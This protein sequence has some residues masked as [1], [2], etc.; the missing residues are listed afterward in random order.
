MDKYKYILSSSLKGEL[1][2]DHLPVGHETSE[3]ILEKSDEFD[4]VFYHYSQGS[5]EFYG[6]A[7]PYL[8]DLIKQQGI[9]LE[10]TIKILRKKRLSSEYEEVYTG[11]LN[12]KDYEETDNN[13]GSI[14]LSIGESDTTES[15]LS[16]TDTVIG[17]DSDKGI[18]DNDLTI[19]VDKYVELYMT[20]MEIIT[21]S[22]GEF[23]K[24]NFGY[25]ISCDNNLLM[26]MVN[27]SANENVLSPAYIKVENLL[28][29]SNGGFTYFT[30]SRTSKVKIDLS[31]VIYPSVFSDNGIM[32]NIAT[33]DIIQYKL[34]S[35]GDAVDES[36]NIIADPD[37][38]ENI[39]IRKNYEIPLVVHNFGDTFWTESTQIIDTVEINMES[40]QCLII[41]ANSITGAGNFII[42]VPHGYAQSINI[43]ISEL[44]VT[45]NIKAIKPYNL[46]R[47]LVESMTG[48]T[49]NF[50]APIFE[51]GGEYEN[52][53]STNGLMLRGFTAAVANYATSFSDYFQSW[54]I[55]GNLGLGID[56][57]IVSIEPVDNFYESEVVLVIDDITQLTWSR[58]IDES[59]FY[60][61]VKSGCDKTAYDAE[62]GLKEFNNINE[63]ATPIKR[64]NNKFEAIPAHRIDG[65]GMTLLLDDRAEDSETTD[66]ESD[67]ENFIIDTKK[68]NSNYLQKGR[69]DFDYVTGI[70]GISTPINLNFTPARL[71]YRNSDRFTTGCQ[72]TGTKI[73]LTK[74]T[75]SNSLVTK[76]TGEYIEISEN[77]D[78]VIANLKNPRFSGFVLEFGKPVSFESFQFFKDNKRKRFAV[79][80][81]IT[82]EYH[83]GWIK[84]IKRTTET[85]LANFTLIEQK[86]GQ[87]TNTV[88][89]MID[90]LGNIVVNDNNEKITVNG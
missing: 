63:Y 39:A 11:I 45:R 61:S 74:Q 13:R 15:I 52:C 64:T 24:N 76:K 37:W 71:A 73:K 31:L 27:T 29:V 4:G 83:Y 90:N 62:G 59:L 17:Y 50:S 9:N 85:N 65:Y 23:Q 81:P 72:L 32:L 47:R 48:K 10:C 53:L 42:S 26:S 78:L 5:I 8:S 86:D 36:G 46:F 41:Y 18:D 44:P 88:V 6:N 49:N 57:D 70:D 21:K 51:D 19:P 75:A 60:P 67:S 12:G 56:D 69:D 40:N 84:M 35:D 87:M 43:S 20:G 30:E 80:N 34:N 2:L 16:R 79:K 55:L 38:I 25:G 33:A 58:K 68:V 89:V 28:K 22:T 7:V 1:T 82:K 66:T 14:K 54:K 3:E 77:S